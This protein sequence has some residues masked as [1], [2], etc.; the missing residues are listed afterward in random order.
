M[1]V[2]YTHLLDENIAK[3]ER[4]FGPVRLA[5]EQSLPPMAVKGEA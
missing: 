2:S 3:Y 1:A 4:V 5:D